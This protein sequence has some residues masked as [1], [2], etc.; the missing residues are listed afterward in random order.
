MAKVKLYIDEDLTDR[1]AVALRSRKFD[2]ISAHEVEMRGKTDREQLDYAIKNGRVILTRN[3]RHF[4]KLQ[5]E[6]FEKKINHHGILVTDYLDFKKLL[7][8]LLNFLNRITAE[9]M[10]NRFEW[11]QNYK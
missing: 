2:V 11:L 8:R 9:E 1:L 6:Y 7:Q 5:R 10:E 3:V 4:V